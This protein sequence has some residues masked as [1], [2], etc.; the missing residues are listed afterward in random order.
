MQYSHRVKF[1]HIKQ[2]RSQMFFFLGRMV[3]NRINT[4]QSFVLPSACSHSCIFTLI[5]GVLSEEKFQISIEVEVLFLHCMSDFRVM[6]SPCHG[7]QR[8][9][10]HRA[11]AACIQSAQ[12]ESSLF[13]PPQSCRNQLYY[14]QRWLHP[15]NERSSS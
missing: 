7:N 9:K 5:W 12:P 8:E 10:T 15:L 3:L 1:Y 6:N 2:I 13:S 4:N 11:D 14:A